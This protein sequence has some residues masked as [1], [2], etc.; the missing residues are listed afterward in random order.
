MDIKQFR[1]IAAEMLWFSV[2]LR[3]PGS[4]LI[5]LQS[6]L[7]PSLNLLNWIL[8]FVL[9]GRRC[10]FSPVGPS[11]GTSLSCLK[12][13]GVKCCYPVG[14][15]VGSTFIFLASSHRGNFCSGPMRCK[16]AASQ[17]SV[18]WK[19]VTFKGSGKSLWECIFWGK[20]ITR[21]SNISWWQ[22]RWEGGW[23]W[24]HVWLTGKESKGFM[25]ELGEIECGEESKPVNNPCVIDPWAKMDNS[26]DF[27]GTNAPGS[28]WEVNILSKT[29]CNV[30]AM[31][32]VTGYSEGNELSA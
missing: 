9:L 32:G 10:S 12:G 17:H 30:H 29:Q 27:Q 23:N 31:D 24:H 2:G 25:H 11:L 6:H 19:L 16:C 22:G 21:L 14:D 3:C 7:H 15:L 5:L 13:A 26:Q 4:L 8:E 1:F 18:F 20:L 28:C